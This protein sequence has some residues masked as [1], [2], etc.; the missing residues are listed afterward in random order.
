MFLFLFL[1]NCKYIIR[2]KDMYW[3]SKIIYFLHWIY[4]HTHPFERLYVKLVYLRKSDLRK[5]IEQDILQPHKTEN[6]KG[7]NIGQFFIIIFKLS[8]WRYVKV[9]SNT[10]HIKSH[11]GVIFF[12][13]LL[14]HFGKRK[15]SLV[16]DI[17]F[18]NNCT[19]NAWREKQT[20]KHMEEEMRF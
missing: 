4:I 19:I 9:F 8:L 13:K 5:H 11:K 18:L 3:W 6:K 16:Y 17:N 7:Q 20:H 2:K 1:F 10:C 14:Q 15:F 12:R